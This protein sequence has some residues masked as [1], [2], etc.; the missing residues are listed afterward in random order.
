[1][2][3]LIFTTV[4]KLQFLHSTVISRSAVVVLSKVLVAFLCDHFVLMSFLL[5]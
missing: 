4:G 1:M 3:D 2:N 5:V